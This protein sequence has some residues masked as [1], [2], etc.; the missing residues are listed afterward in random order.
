M[1]TVIQI[2]RTANVTAPSTSDITEG[3]L[4]YSED[5]SNNGSGA[6]LYIGSLNSGGSAVVDTIGGKYYT[7]KVDASTSTNTNNTIVQRDTSGNFAAGTITATLS[8]SATSANI[9]SY[10]N[11]LTTPR[12]I[13]LAGD[14][15]GNVTFNGSQN[16][17][18]TATIAPNSVALGTD[19][20]G[21]Y[22]AN[23]IPGTGLTG[24][25]F[26]TEGATPTLTLATSGVSA[27]T[28]GG[29]SQIPVI[30]VDTFGR[31]TS[32]A[33]TSI[34]IASSSFTTIA[35]AGQSNIEADSST[36][37]LTL[38]NTLG[39]VIAT[40]ASS[41]TLTFSL[42]NTGV[43]ATTYGGTTQVPV[44]TFDAQGRATSAS[45][46]SLSSYLTDSSIATLT[47]KTFDV[48]VG[49][50]NKFSIQSNE[51]SS[52]TG[53][54][55]VVVLSQSPTISVLNISD[56]NLNID[57]GTGS[58]FWSGQSGVLQSGNYKAG[59]YSST[60][61]GPDSLFTFGAASANT[62]SVSVEGSLFVGTAMPSNN[63]GL[64]TAYDGWLVVQSGGKFGGT[65]NTLGALQFDDAAT[66]KVIFADG[67]EQ[68]TAFKTS[69]LT[70]AN[71]TELT[72]LYFTNAR[73]RA[74]LTSGNGIVYSSSTGNITLSAT[75]VGESTYGSAA[76]VPVFTVDAYGRLSA[77]SNVNI[78]IPSSALTTDVALGSQT[79]GA[80][81]ANL[82]AGTGISISGLGNEGTTPTITNSGVTSLAGTTNQIT[83]S[84]STGSITLS[85]PNALVAPGD[86]TVTGN[87]IVSGTA[88]T[89]DTAS[90]VVEDPLVRFGNAN[91][92]DTLDI[93]FFGQYTSSGTKFAGLFRDA[94]D[95]GKFKLFTD[96][97][98][99]PTTNVVDTASYTVATLVS[100]LTGGTVS[101]LTANIV[102]GDGGTGRGTLTTNAVLY[103]QGTSAVGLA[104]G[105]AGQVLQLNASGVPTFAGLDGG[106]Y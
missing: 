37:T 84:A 77:A 46:V 26:G 18:L 56:S 8:G 94:S 48:S 54:G 16:V 31:I 11:V 81:V 93:G 73:A 35:V 99:D 105:T 75:G 29:T 53:S 106:S 85:L 83:A 66:G 65:I 90:V 3:E 98:V 69:V 43:S 12:D 63:G 5:K 17:T 2:K 40:D 13:G 20:T 103:G 72:N 104:T 39:V 4:A 62:M 21:N 23:V 100:S 50:N 60:T 32:A 38:A 80:Y 96:L 86:L 45:N 9:A 87:L 27:N 10:A 1:A 92:S 7:A 91:P 64:S 6:R 67:T 44:I 70:T 15:T 42:S 52:Y 89:M 30:T 24:S 82:V 88:V 68:N 57:G 97:T 49:S 47:N 36:D 58:F 71:V 51:I 95:S 102:V 61:N 25:G 14:L 101:G 59:I 74:A 79:S 28:Y 19:T 34:S 78:A 55:A 22:V 76:I 33:N 41:D